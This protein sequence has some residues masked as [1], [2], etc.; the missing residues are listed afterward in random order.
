[1]KR[2]KL[3]AVLARTLFLTFFI[4]VDLRAEESDKKELEMEM[5][6]IF[7]KWS[8]AMNEGDLDTW[9]QT[10]ATFRKVGIRN[11]IVSQ[12]KKWPESTL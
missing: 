4:I 3:L 8:K 5:F 12:K 1:M 7:Q 11:M 6:S 10:T 9:Q 2:N